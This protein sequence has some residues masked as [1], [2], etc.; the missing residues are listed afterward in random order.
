M[1]RE[2]WTKYRRM[3]RQGRFP[4]AAPRVVMV[5]ATSLEDPLTVSLRD[6]LAYFKQSRRTL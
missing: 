6:R 2:T 5:V 3:L 1:N 4:D